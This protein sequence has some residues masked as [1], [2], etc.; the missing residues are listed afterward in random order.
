MRELIGEM[1]DALFDFS[2]AQVHRADMDSDRSKIL[3]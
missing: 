1:A 3:L 2:I